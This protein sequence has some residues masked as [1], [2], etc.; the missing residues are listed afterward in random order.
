[1]HPSMTGFKLKVNNIFQKLRSEKKLNL[2]ADKYN[3][4]VG[5][6][7]ILPEVLMASVSRSRIQD[8]FIAAGAIDK[9][10]F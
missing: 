10:K 6:A 9:I 3:V 8:G 7:V 5:F 4:V 1:M 2:S